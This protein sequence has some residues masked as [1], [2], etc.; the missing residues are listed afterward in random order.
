MSRKIPSPL[1]V[2]DE[3][4]PSF[5]FFILYLFIACIWKHGGSGAE[6]WLEDNS[7]RHVVLRIELR[8]SGLAV[9]TFAC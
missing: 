7:F 8:V 5:I 3:L 2:R 6:G 1:K 9:S 4:T